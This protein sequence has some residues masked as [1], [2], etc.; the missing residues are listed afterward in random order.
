MPRPPT[1]TLMPYTD[2]LADI[3]NPATWAD[4]T[5]DFWTWNTGDGYTNLS[6]IVTYGEGAM[7]YIDTAL[8]GSEALIDA[9]ARKYGSRS[10][11]VTDVSGGY[12]PAD[13]T[14]VTADGLSYLRKAGETV[15]P[16]LDG[17]LP[18]GAETS[19]HYGYT[20]VDI[21][22]GDGGNFSNLNEAL[23]AVRRDYL[24]RNESVS[25]RLTDDF[26]LEEQVLIDGYDMSHVRIVPET[27]GREVTIV[28]SALT[29][30]SYGRF[31]ALAAVRG[32]KLPLISTL[33]NMDTSGTAT[34][35]DG[36]QAIDRAFVL[37][38]AG[39]GVKN[40]A[41]R[42]VHCAI[43][44]YAKGRDV[45]ITGAGEAN[46]RNGG[47]FVEFRES[48]LTGGAVGLRAAGAGITDFEGSNLSSCV[49]GFEIFESTVRF[50]N[51][52]ATG[53]GEGALVD[54]LGKLQARG[55]NFNGATG[56][57]AL[58][59][60]GGSEINLNGGSA[61]NAANNAVYISAGSFFGAGADLSGAGGSAVYMFGGKAEVPSADLSNATD[62]GIQ[63]R[64]G[65]HCNAEG[66]DATGAGVDGFASFNGSIIN[67]RNSSG[68]IANTTNAI[69]GNGIV[70][71]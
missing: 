44:S 11:F 7:D 36:I 8:A 58:E 19:W 1:P 42:G 53:C 48:D 64:N 62:Y 9:V 70:F 61:A 12:A 50:G 15:L 35:R 21:S 33:F 2:Q 67:A 51:G 38:A 69:T 16:G 28:R 18:F 55:A 52:V 63:A 37:I 47:G 17:W 23:A 56:S 41:A 5:V 29:E 46:V 39:G 31:P 65:A 25:L 40:A 4:R 66:A 43:F 13:G 6:S 22:V 27:F 34:M 10:A 45:V 57:R 3:N 71:K 24:V 60:R 54:R 68:T 26:V 32:G 49:L 14:V 20:G 59:M 30:S